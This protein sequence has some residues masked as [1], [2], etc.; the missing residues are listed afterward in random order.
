MYKKQIYFFSKA[1]DQRA[2]TKSISVPSKGTELNLVLCLWSAAFEKK[3]ISCWERNRFWSLVFG[4]LLL[5]RRQFP[6]WNGT[7]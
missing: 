6:S 3:S 1:A 5:R 2:R 4:L 7:E